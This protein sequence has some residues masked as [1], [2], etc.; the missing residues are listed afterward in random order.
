M[1]RL[2]LLLALAAVAA[3]GVGSAQ[4]QDGEDRR[5]GERN[6]DAKH[7]IRTRSIDQI[8]IVDSDTL[9][10]RMRGDEVYRN[11]LPYNCPGLR[12]GDTL[13]YRTTIGQMCDLDVVTVLEDWGFGF[14]P[15]A[16]CGLGMFHPIDEQIADEL[17]QADRR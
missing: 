11:D 13:M 10:F 3:A 17:L 6:P 2:K 15:G 7:C 16:S 8:D 5:A 4:E 14:A 9:V 12:E 1:Y